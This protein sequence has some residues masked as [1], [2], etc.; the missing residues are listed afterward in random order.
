MAVTLMVPLLML[1]LHILTEL[2]RPISLSLRLRSN[3]WGDEML[4][5]M[6]SSFGLKA[7]PLII[8]GMGLAL[9]A[10]VVQ[11]L[12]FTLLTTIYLAI[13]LNHEE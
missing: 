6:L 5:G 12:V 11:A 10:A 4:V 13:V 3:I 7:M 1:F 9:I 8:F 2:I